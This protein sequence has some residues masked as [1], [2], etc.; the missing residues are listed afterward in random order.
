MTSKEG[1]NVP[2][3][4]TQAAL[5]LPQSSEAV[6][7][8]R[9]SLGTSDQIKAPDLDTLFLESPLLSQD[10]QNIIRNF[11]SDS[12]VSF[13]NGASEMKFNLQRNERVNDAGEAIIEMIKLRLTSTPKNWQKVRT[14]KAKDKQKIS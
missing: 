13:P 3:N 5:E 10:D 7:T 9:T 8:A 1:D 12:F 4:S 11:F 14:T 2:T 6:P